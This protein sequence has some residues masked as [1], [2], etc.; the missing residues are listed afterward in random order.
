MKK[1]DIIMIYEDPQTCKIPEGQAKLLRKLTW[2]DAE[3]TLLWSVK[4]LDTGD[5]V[6]RFIKKQE[7][8]PRGIDHGDGNRTGAAVLG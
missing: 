2:G 7:P 6:D 8:G 4:F 5:V 3:D 1:G